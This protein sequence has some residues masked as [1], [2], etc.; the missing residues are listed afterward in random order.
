MHNQTGTVAVNFDASGLLPG[1]YRCDLVAGDFYNNKFVI[2]VTLH[3]T[4]PVS[5][6]DV[7]GTTGTGLRSCVP[8]PF[9][10]ETRIHYELAA[11]KQVTI[12]IYSLQG[13]LVRSWKHDAVPA[14]GQFQLWD[15]TDEQGNLVPPGV[16]TCRL[17]TN[18][19]QGCLKM[20]LIR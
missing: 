10:A 8:N 4:F 7:K 17:M 19:Y 2:P 6:N 1:I 15:G 5:V 11:V 9:T 14:G 12:E 18:D 13:L 16:Y 20:V 3:V